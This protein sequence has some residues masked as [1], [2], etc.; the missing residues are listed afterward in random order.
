MMEHP[1]KH[2]T[3]VIADLGSGGAQK[4]AIGLLEH[5]QEQGHKV[6]LVTLDGGTRDFYTIPK[7]IKKIRLGL[8]GESR[9]F[10]AA[11]K[12][13]LSRIFALRRAIRD[14][15]PDSVI[16]FGAVMNIQTILASMC[17]GIRLVISERND[18]GRQSFGNR[19]DWL[20]RFLYRYADIVTANSK[21]ALDSMRGYVGAHQLHF[22]PN[23]YQPP[24][25]LVIS[26]GA[27][28]ENTILLVGRLHPQ[29]DHM[30]LL[31]AFAALSVDYPD[32][33]LCLIG[34]GAL[35]QELEYEAH[36]LDIADRVRFEGR[37][38]NL[39]PWYE[40]A[41]L[42]VL[43]S[44]HEGTPNALLEAIGY[45]VPVIVSDAVEGIDQAKLDSCQLFPARDVIALS[46]KMRILMRDP[47]RARQLAEQQ[48]T[49]LTEHDPARV[50]QV[51]DELL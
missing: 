22:V 30:S 13:N 20:R 1:A 14:S 50:F 33:S 41:R 6:T 19:W 27:D 12:A 39:V 46:G 29:K 8:T 38:E 31:K 47:V 17:L 9:S 40:K 3:F 25:G 36:Q 23:Q 43:P 4:I 28:R 10:I 2:I 37:I 7:G 44:V 18:P 11:I 5:W 45:G 15:R 26:S 48:M 24:T 16:S 34:E 49:L 21:N 32:W 35:R 42:F 51:W